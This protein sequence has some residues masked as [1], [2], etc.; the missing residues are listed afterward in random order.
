MNYKNGINYTN[1]VF[2]IDLVGPLR[3]SSTSKI[4]LGA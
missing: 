4:S 1:S 2:S 3:D